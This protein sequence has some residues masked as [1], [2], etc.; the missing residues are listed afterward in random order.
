MFLFTIKYLGFLKFIPGLAF[1]FDCWLKIWT[2]FTNPL[3]LDM[4][5]D[6]EAEVLKWKDTNAGFHKYG[7]LQLNHKGKEIGHIH[8]NG[9]LD[10]LLTRSVKRQLIEEGLIR[11][12]HSF[13]NTGWISFY[14]E[15][16]NDKE[17]ALK[18][19]KIGYNRLQSSHHASNNPHH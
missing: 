16:I 2:L 6:I 5:D 13:K 1:A 4:M 3:I 8:S 7:G 11:D 17:Y 9:L 14:M 18:L 12:H 15:S 19:L 10:M